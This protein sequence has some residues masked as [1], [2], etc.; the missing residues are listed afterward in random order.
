MLSCNQNLLVLDCAVIR[1]L[2]GKQNYELQPLLGDGLMLLLELR[3]V[4]TSFDFI[5][6]F[7]IQ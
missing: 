6:S 5:L 7:V 3:S 2:M 1:A 4:M